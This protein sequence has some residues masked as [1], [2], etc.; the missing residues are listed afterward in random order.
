MSNPT[1]RSQEKSPASRH[2]ASK[3][4]HLAQSTW[5]DL[6]GPV[7]LRLLGKSLKRDY[8]GLVSE[9]LDP[10][11]YSDAVEF[12]RDYLAAS[13]VSKCPDWDLGIDLDAVA[14]ESFIDS[15]AR[16]SAANLRLRTQYVNG[17]YSQFTPES[18]IRSAQ[19]KISG[20]LGPFSWDDAES[21]FGF[22]PGATMTRPSRE[23]DPYYK[24]KAKP[25]VTQS[26]AIL[27]YTA[28]R[29]VPLWYNRV[30][31][32]T[33]R[34]LEDFEA[35]PLNKRLAE[36]FSIVKGNRV[37]FVPKDAKKNRTIA[38]EPTMNGYIQHGIGGLIR[39]RLRRATIGGTDVSRID[40]NNQSKNQQLACE[41]SETDSLATVDLKAASDSVSLELVK[42]LLPDDWFQAICLTRS[43][44]GVL[45]DGTQVE[46]QKVS[47]MGNGYTF[48]LESLIFWALGR[49]VVDLLR[50]RDTRVSVYG[51]DI[52][53]PKQAWPTLRWMLTYVGFQTNDDKTFVDGP[54][55]ESCG[56]HYFRGLDVTPI[57]IRKAVDV[58]SR[59]I[60]FANQI[61]RWSRLSW[62]LD[63][64]LRVTYEYAV[65]LLPRALRSPSIPD[66]LGDFALF[67]DFIE[68]GP[69]R[70]RFH[71]DLWYARMWVP[72]I[73]T[74]KPTDDAYL[75]RQLSGGG[76]KTSIPISNL[77]F[78]GNT[79]GWLWKSVRFVDSASGVPFPGMGPRWHYLKQV[80]VKRWDSF[81]P[82]LTKD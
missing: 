56:K 12:R 23:G 66:G 20:L 62:G 73:K 1:G 70:S 11:S 52:V 16:C 80:P 64:T 81:G 82:W 76:H 33:G 48:E 41:G 3:V 54:F 50:L 67:G 8:L 9:S 78:M 68:C 40:L 25:C 75:L 61:R 5:L 65:K 31:S 51:D 6:G 14:L 46:Y 43:P 44:F 35:L 49:A 4:L 59:L 39:R 53:V 63:D 60:W 24:Y 37:H 72:V 22:G 19:L 10:S 74:R 13:L 15:E 30:V 36:M 18:I 57:Y 27:A 79:E 7:S 29:R 77:P 38:I 47:S 71:L 34:S 28:I 32:L 42:L 17:L 45:P 69:Q 2:F 21:L 26:C 55:R 58:P